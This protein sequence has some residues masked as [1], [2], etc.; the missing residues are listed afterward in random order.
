LEGL[1]SGPETA[2]GHC[3]VSGLILSRLFVGSL[4][5]GA[6]PPINLDGN[7][8]PEPK[9]LFAS[10]RAAI[11]GLLP[12]TGVGCPAFIRDQAHRLVLDCREAV[13]PPTS[14][15]LGKGIADVT[16]QALHYGQYGCLKMYVN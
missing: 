16:G 12:G 11:N 15:E 7:G 5:A 1:F 10:V 2:E 9:A 8:G 14:R 13:I 4:G 6:R 3:R